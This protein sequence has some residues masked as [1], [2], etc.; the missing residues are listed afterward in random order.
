MSLTSAFLFSASS[1][2]FIERFTISWI[3][4]CFSS[5]VSMMLATPVLE[6][7]TGSEFGDECWWLVLDPGVDGCEVSLCRWFFGFNIL[8]SVPLAGSEREG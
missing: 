6:I 1:A 5:G 2:R 8:G 4:L 7:S 3:L